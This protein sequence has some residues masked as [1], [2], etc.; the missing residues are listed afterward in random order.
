M[1]MVG[2]A[3][4]IAFVEDTAVDPDRLPEFYERFRRRSSTGTGSAPPA[5]ATPTSAACTSGRSST[6]RRDEGVGARSGRSR[7]RSPT[8]SSSSAAR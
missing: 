5:T 6:S 4:P 2:D 1:A 3:K 7:A 8:W